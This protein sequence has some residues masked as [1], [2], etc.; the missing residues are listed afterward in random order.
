M[1]YKVT[2][3]ESLRVAYIVKAGT[4]AEAL[5]AVKKMEET[6]NFADVVSSEDQDDGYQLV[7]IDEWGEE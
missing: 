5:A 7:D 6:H 3:K 4:R 1:L 2:V